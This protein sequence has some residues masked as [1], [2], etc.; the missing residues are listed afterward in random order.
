M[1]RNNRLPEG[2]DGHVIADMNVD[3]MPWYAPEKENP[4][5][6]WLGMPRETLRAKLKALFP[7]SF[8]AIEFGSETPGKIAPAPI[9]IPHRP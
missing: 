4:V 8:K 5:P 1:T 3:G 2:D 7:K 9:R 6:E